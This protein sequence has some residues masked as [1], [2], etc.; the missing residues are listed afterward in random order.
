MFKILLTK[1]AEKE[2][3]SLPIALQA[4]TLQ[5]IEKLAKEGHLLREPDVKTLAKGLK[6]L[7]V[8]SKEG[9]SRSFFFFM[10]GKR[11]YIV[12]ILQKKAQKTPQRILALA[13]SRMQKLQ[14]ELENDE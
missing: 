3:L 13:Y 5:A 2:L 10:R 7:R 6:E 4:A 8:N 1:Q 12:H 9:I 14:K 11:A